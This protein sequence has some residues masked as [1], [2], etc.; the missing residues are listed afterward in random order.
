MDDIIVFEPLNRT[1]LCS[2]ARKELAKLSNR[3]AELGYT[4]EISPECE[5]YAAEKCLSTGGSARDIRRFAEQEAEDILCDSILSDC[6]K[7][8]RLDIKNGRPVICA[9]DLSGV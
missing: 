4:L 2:I 8:L 5:A 1:A 9:P 7:N 6:E 3:A